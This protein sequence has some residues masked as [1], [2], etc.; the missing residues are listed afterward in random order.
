[1]AV[2]LKHV[3]QF[4]TIDGMKW[5]PPV[6]CSEVAASHYLY[7]Y[8]GPA[9]YALASLAHANVSPAAAVVLDQ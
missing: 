1:M 9:F 8:V 6:V 7:G 2:T 3:G 4:V 5:L